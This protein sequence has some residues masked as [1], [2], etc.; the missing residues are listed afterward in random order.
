ML[1][2]LKE[3]ALLVWNFRR[4]P[5][6]ES[7]YHKLDP[8]IYRVSLGE[9]MEGIAAICRSTTGEDLRSESSHGF[10]DSRFSIFEMAPKKFLLFHY[11]EAK[12]IVRLTLQFV[13]TENGGFSAVLNGH[14]SR[15]EIKPMVVARLGRFVNER[16]RLCPVH[17]SFDLEN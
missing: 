4:G 9:E 12:E 2:A 10:S 5:A 8:H 14:C 13:T 3:R 7:S 1:E 16:C 11:R 15:P 17:F 6:V